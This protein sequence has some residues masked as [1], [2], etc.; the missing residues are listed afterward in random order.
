M[1]DW[2]L[3]SPGDLDRDTVALSPGDSMTEGSSVG[4]SDWYRHWGHWDCWGHSY[5]DDWAHRETGRGKG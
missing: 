4:H 5:R 3:D 1:T 2:G